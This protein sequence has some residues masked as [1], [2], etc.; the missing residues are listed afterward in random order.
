MKLFFSLISVL[1]ISSVSMAYKDGNYTCA[2][3]KV[4]IKTVSLG[5]GVELPYM[6]VQ[7]FLSEGYALKGIARIFLMDS[8]E[9]LELN[10]GSSVFR[11]TFANGNVVNCGVK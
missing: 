2:N 3:K 6:E 4:I 1:M 10:L 9:H 5:S 7:N 11:M 8:R